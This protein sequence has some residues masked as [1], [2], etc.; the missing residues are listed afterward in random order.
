MRH[1]RE[2]HSNRHGHFNRFRI[3]D[4]HRYAV[5]DVDGYVHANRHRNGD[6]DANGH[7]NSNGNRDTDCH[8][9]LR[10]FG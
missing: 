6:I 5:T 10:A 3:P 7:I 8:A 9:D 4:A 1:H 2:T